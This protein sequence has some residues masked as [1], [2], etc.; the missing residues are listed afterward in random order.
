MSVLAFGAIFAGLLQI[1]HVTHVVDHF[2]EPT[3]EGSEFVGHEPSDGL[4]NL[5]LVLGTVV[6]LA[7]IALAWF[8][9]VRR[10]ELPGRMRERVGALYELSLHKWYFDEAYDRGIV[11][12]MAEAG[13]FCRD[14][15]ERWV[16]DG[17]LVGGT[18]NAVRA[19]SALV[20]AVQS[21]YLRAYAAFLVAG[22]VGVGVY[23]LVVSS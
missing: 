21:G 18:T 22:I 14:R 12:P 11:H 16:I 20:R 5:G 19:G 2:L 4:I 7:G 17:A 1:P 15:F 10:P 8:L 6:G 3:F 13:R 9:W 23:F